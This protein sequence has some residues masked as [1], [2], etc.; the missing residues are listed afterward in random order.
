MWRGGLQSSNIDGNTRLCTS[1]AATAL[2]A[3]FGSDGPVASYADVD[4]ADLLCLY[5]HNVA[6]TQ[7]VLWE[8][9]LSARQKNGGRIIVVDPRTTPTVRQGADLHL[10]VKVGTNVALMN[11]II[12]LLIARGQV[13]R[14]FVAQHTIGFDDVA[15]VARESP[16]DRVAAIK[17]AYRA[18]YM[19]GANLADAKTQ[20]AD[21]ARDSED[22]RAFLDFIER[23][24]RPQAAAL[25][26]PALEDHLFHAHR[27]VA[28]E[29]RKLRHVAEAQAGAAFEPAGGGRE[30]TEDQADE[31]ALAAAVRPQEGEAIP[32]RQ[33]EI[34]P[35]ENDIGTEAERNTLQT[36]ERRGTRGRGGSVH[37]LMILHSHGA[38]SSDVWP[39]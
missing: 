3:T 12:H 39:P 9:M 24:E 17:R 13:D 29:R 37:P 21:M 4:Q 36:N 2:T 5:G 35:L 30:Q 26:Q 28:I 22:V 6:E 16:P 27:E 11:G 32:F 25:A 15:A 19:S 33:R 18:L 23:G 14:D 1:S 8:R 7:T 10:Q 31:R 38:S 34:A 20:L